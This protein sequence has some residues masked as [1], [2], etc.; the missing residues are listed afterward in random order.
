MAP[1]LV[2][3]AQDLTLVLIRGALRH[4]EHI[5]DL[6]LMPKF[7]YVIKS[8]YPVQWK[9]YSTYKQVHL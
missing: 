4:K 8:Y 1:A 7:L 6:L 5:N 9:C 3:R 2:N